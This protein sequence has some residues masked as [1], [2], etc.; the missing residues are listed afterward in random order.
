M[1]VSSLYMAIF[2]DLPRCVFNGFIFP[3]FWNLGW[4]FIFRIFVASKEARRIAL[5]LFLVSIYVNILTVYFPLNTVLFWCIYFPTV[6]F[7]FSLVHDVFI[8]KKSV[9]LV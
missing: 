9:D 2:G 5:H 6:L 1:F 3:V 4:Y 8:M 7:Y